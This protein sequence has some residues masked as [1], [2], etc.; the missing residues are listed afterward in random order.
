MVLEARDRFGQLTT[1]LFAL[2]PPELSGL[3]A[4]DGTG[5]IAGLGTGQATWI[6]VP[7]SEAAPTISKEHFVGGTLSYRQAGALI[8]VPLAPTSITVL[9][10]PKLVVRYF[11]QRDVVSDDP[12]TPIIEPSEPFSLAVMVQNEGYGTAH[13][14]RITSG[15]PQII[16]NEKGLLIGFEVIGAEVGGAPRQPS[17][18]VDFGDIGPGR[19]PSV[20]GC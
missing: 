2:R 8:T 16:E 12:F 14:M 20:A 19:L 7:T 11:H 17:L 9:P 10:N 15:Q 18:T 5:V 13:H 4:V 1:S 3:T 6:L